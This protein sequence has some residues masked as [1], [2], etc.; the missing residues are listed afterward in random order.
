MSLML[1]SYKQHLTQA[2]TLSPFAGHLVLSET[3]M[4]IFGPCQMVLDRTKYQRPFGVDQKSPWT[5]W[6]GPNMTKYQGP[7]GVDQISHGCF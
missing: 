2:G 3:S 1:L 7:F 4:S 5:F 6:T